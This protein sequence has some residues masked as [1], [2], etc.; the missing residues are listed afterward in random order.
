MSLV[1]D[2]PETRG[3]PARKRIMHKRLKHPR[4]DHLLLIKALSLRRDPITTTRQILLN[5]PG[6]SLRE[7]KGRLPRRRNR[8]SL[9]PSLNQIM[10]KNPPLLLLAPRHRFKRTNRNN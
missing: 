5:R 4:R 7:R 1:S 8:S 9:P 6:K 10:N 2:P 3:I